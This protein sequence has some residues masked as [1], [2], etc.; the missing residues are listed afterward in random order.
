MVM[1]A[2]PEPARIP[3]P[4]TGPNTGIAPEGLIIEKVN[5]PE[6]SLKFKS[7]SFASEML[8]VFNTESYK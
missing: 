5:V 8:R 6:A 2:V 1:V 4:V 3:D 7:T